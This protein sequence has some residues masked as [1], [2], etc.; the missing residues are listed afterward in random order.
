VSRGAALLKEQAGRKNSKA[1][2]PAIAHLGNLS[3]STSQKSSSAVPLALEADR[4][5]RT[6]PR[7]VD[8]TL[9]FTEHRAPTDMIFGRYII[10]AAVSS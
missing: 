2:T 8:Q 5:P 1:T 7:K 10:G 4:F 3:P 6:L 9:E